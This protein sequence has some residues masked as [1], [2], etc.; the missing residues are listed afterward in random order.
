MDICKK[1]SVLSTIPEL[2]ISKVKNYALLT[3]SHDI[4]T[5]LIKDNTDESVCIE[6][7]EGK[8]YITIDDDVLKYK[9]I[10]SETFDN[11]VKNAVINK[12]SDLIEEASSRLKAILVNTYKDLV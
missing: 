8:I 7:F 4:V 11:M 2:A 10:P 6:T 1:I 3:Q 9:F 12:E 5:Q